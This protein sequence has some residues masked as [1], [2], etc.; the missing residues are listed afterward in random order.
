M[1]GSLLPYSLPSLLSSQT[2]LLPGLL[3]KSQSPASL[4]TA[5][6][7]SLYPEGCAR[8]PPCS[9][10]SKSCSFQGVPQIP[11]T[12]Q[13]HRDTHK[14]LPHVGAPQPW[15]LSP[16]LPFPCPYL[17]NCHASILSLPI[18][19]RKGVFVHKGVFASF[20]GI[21]NLLKSP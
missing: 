10:L 2:G 11:P 19:L 9:F 4:P 8:P 7:G 12:K 17:H 3:C 6:S 16:S 14:F 18:S 21:L 13:I 5:H 20:H 1:W 15:S